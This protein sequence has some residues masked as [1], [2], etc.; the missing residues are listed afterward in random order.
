MTPDFNGSSFIVDEGVILFHAYAHPGMTEALAELDISLRVVPIKKRLDATAGDM[1]LLAR[2]SPKKR[3]WKK[4]LNTMNPQEG[5]A[6]ALE[7]HFVEVILGEGTTKRQKLYD[8][9]LSVD[10][11]RSF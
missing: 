8:F 6:L 3:E 11:A 5:S 2:I 7:N 10:D 1:Q 9:E 4:V